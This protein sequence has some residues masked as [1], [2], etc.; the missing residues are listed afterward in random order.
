[1]ISHSDDIVAM[2][3][4]EMSPGQWKARIQESGD[5]ESAGFRMI[6]GWGSTACTRLK[7]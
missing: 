4:H 5:T 1:L 2:N 6:R 3:K 7:P